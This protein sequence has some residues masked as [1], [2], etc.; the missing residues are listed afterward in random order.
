[1]FRKTIC[2]IICAWALIAAKPDNYES[3]IVITRVKDNKVLFSHNPNKQLI[4]ASVTKLFS[5]A[6]W[7]HHLGPEF[8]MHR[9]FYYSGELKNNTI[10]KDLIIIG[11]GDPFLVSRD[12]WSISQELKLRGIKHVKGNLVI[13]V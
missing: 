3:S 10:S 8:Q 4:P 6:A 13:G 9:K 7:L 2:L 12:L 5:T 11:D 1:M